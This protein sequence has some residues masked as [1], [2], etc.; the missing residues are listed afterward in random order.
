MKILILSPYT[1]AEL[2]SHL[3]MREYNVLERLL[4]EKCGLSKKV[5]LKDTAPWVGDMISELE[6]QE[7]ID[8][9]SV[10]PQIKMAKKVQHFNL[11]KTTYYFYSSDFSQLARLIKSY[12]WWKRI[13]T[14]SS[15]VRKIVDEIKPDI[16]ILFGTENLT[17][18]APILRLTDY[19]I[20][21]ILQTV[22]HKPDR[23]KYCK[24]NEMIMQLETEITEKVKFYGSGKYLGELLKR[25]NPNIVVL[26]YKWISGPLPSLEIPTKK[27]DFVN[28]AFTM[29]I[30][31]GDEDSI[32]ALAIVK[33]TYPHVTMNI[34]G[35]MSPARRNYIENLISE[36]GLNDNV[37]F[38]P[39]FER[40]EDMYRHIL[41]AR[42]AVLPVKLDLVS[43]TTR[44]AMFYRIPVVTNIT[45]GSPLLN[46]EKECVLLAEK[47][48]I[49]SLAEQ[50]C[51]LMSDTSLAISLA[52]NAHEHMLKQLDN[53]KKIDSLMRLLKSIIDNYSKGISIPKELLLDIQS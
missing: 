13:E 14:C 44:E 36:L 53:T 16:I 9:F 12:K 50:M 31:K 37:T 22:Y 41:Q 4:I 29:D 28:F 49:N 32:R 47:G 33:K 23:A 11:N 10:S 52:E 21:C 24:P 25:V 3:Q 27:F 15:R 46:K 19:P 2:R 48:N 26:D 40:K 6:K 34:S 43:T 42:F 35:G 45:P 30:R 8:I 7:N 1:N 18:S 51:R 20:F 38:T 5:I 39:M 17:I